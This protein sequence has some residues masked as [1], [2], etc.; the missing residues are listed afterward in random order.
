MFA[1]G[2]IGIVLNIPGKT[3]DGVKSRLDLLEMGL[4][5]GLAPMFGLKQTYL[6]PACYTLSRKEKK[7]VL[8]TLADLKVPEGYCS[9]FRNLCPWKS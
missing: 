1:R 9:N 7:I 6:P 8:Q 5:L 3:K 4:R 2:I